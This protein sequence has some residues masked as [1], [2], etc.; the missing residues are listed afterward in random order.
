MSAEVRRV[1]ERVN[2]ELFNQAD[3]SVLEALVSE[4]FVEHNPLPGVTS[5]RAGLVTLIRRSHVGLSGLHT[6]IHELISAGDRVASRW[7]STGVHSGDY[8]GAPPTGRRIAID[9]MD[10]ARIENGRLAEHW[11]QIDGVGLLTQ[12]GLAD[13][14]T[15]SPPSCRPAAASTAAPTS[16]ASGCETV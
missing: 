15:T 8:F 3:F 9:G 14:A 16:C 5:D 10:F 2:E 6:Q 13:T 7:T 12:L 4:D 11:T 1:L